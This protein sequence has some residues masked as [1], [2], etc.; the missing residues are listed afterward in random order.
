MQQEKLETLGTFRPS[1]SEQLKNQ[2]R[3]TRRV[4]WTH[5]RA[6]RLASREPRDSCSFFLPAACETASSIAGFSLFQQALPPT[7]RFILP[8]LGPSHYSWSLYHLFIYF[9]PFPSLRSFVQGLRYLSVGFPNSP[10]N[11]HL[12]PFPYDSPEPSWL[13]NPPSEVYSLFVFLIAP[14]VATGT[15]SLLSWLKMTLRTPF[16]RRRQ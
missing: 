6:H 4:C 8:P 12:H 5:P 7:S 3:S 10:F 1:G 16:S 14:V 2:S 9:F 11:Y 15:P 13:T